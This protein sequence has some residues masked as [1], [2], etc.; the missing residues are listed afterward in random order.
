MIYGIRGR[1]KGRKGE[2]FTNL[3][4]ISVKSKTKRDRTRFTFKAVSEE[5]K[6]SIKGSTI[7]G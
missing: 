7:R 2:G 1:V 3:D 6:N 5:N 4:Q